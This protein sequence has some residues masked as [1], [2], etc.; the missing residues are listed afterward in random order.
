[1]KRS[2]PLKRKTRLRARGKTKYRRRERDLEYMRKVKR[3]PCIVR[4]YAQQVR[5]EALV[6]GVDAPSVTTCSG[7]VQADHMGKRGLGQKADDKTCVGICQTHHGER[8]DYRGYFKNWTA[9]DMRSF[10]DWAIEW[11]QA[12]VEE[13]SRG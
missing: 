1:M 11:T 6:R 10:C 12:R 8:T 13:T 2:T 5:L 7:P 3:L 4:V 9:V